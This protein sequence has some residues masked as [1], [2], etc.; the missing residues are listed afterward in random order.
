MNSSGGEVEAR[1]GTTFIAT[2][3]HVTDS[4]Y[5]RDY[6]EVTVTYAGVNY[7]GYVWNSSLAPDV[8]LVITSAPAQTARLAKGTRPQIGDAAVSIGTAGGIV[9]TT[10]QGIVSG[11]SDQ[12][13]NT[14]VP[15]GHGASGGP[16]FTNDGELIGL[17]VAG[18]GS[19]TVATA[20]PAFCDSVYDSA[21]CASPIWPS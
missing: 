3:G 11:V 12:E 15:S 16:M 7:P 21:W 10:T 5:Y 2:A 9:S 4:C 6:R 1:Y 8:S 17:V 13:L 19:L 18:N 20:L 14:T